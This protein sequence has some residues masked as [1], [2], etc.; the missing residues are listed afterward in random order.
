MLTKRRMMKKVTLKSALDVQTI[1]VFGNKDSTEIVAIQPNQYTISW[2]MYATLEDGQDIE[3]LSLEQNI[4]YQR[5]CHFLKYY[6]NN[7]LW[8]DNHCCRTI[9]THFA[10]TDNVFLVT[11][12]VNITFLTNCLFAK[13]NSI[14][15][16]SITVSKI[17]VLDQDTGIAYDYEDE[18]G[19]IP[20]VLPYQKD[21]MGELSIYDT[22]WWER[23]DVSSYDNYALDE[24]E[25]KAVRKTLSENQDVLEE[26]FDAIEKEV[27]SQ[28]GQA[29]MIESGEVVDLEQHRRKK[30]KWTPKLV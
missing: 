4:S 14:C 10:S 23:D 5:I 20:D 6:V 24:E 17:S 9:E 26:D 30:K 19:Q 12:D 16:P 22:C 18:Y 21:F 7:C 11:P 28:M 2:G 29:G 8:Y 15:K 3:Q 25:L 13:F 1:A 27:K